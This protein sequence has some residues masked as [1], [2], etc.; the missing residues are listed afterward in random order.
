MTSLTL[1]ELGVL[2]ADLNADGAIRRTP[3]NDR[4]FDAGI[5]TDQLDDPESYSAT[6][7]LRLIDDEEQLAV[8]TEIGM[9]DAIVA[10]TAAV[11]TL[12]KDN[13]ALKQQIELLAAANGELAQGLVSNVEAIGT[14]ALLVHNQQADS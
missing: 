9:M 3:N 10:L 8:L 7:K 4:E 12:Q 2:F 11:Q 14:L 6:T 13:A 5:R 1:D